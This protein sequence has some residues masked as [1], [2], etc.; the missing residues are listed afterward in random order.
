MAPTASADAGSNARVPALRAHAP[1]TLGTLARVRTGG[2]CVCGASAGHAARRCVGAR[3]LNRVG[4]G[5]LLRAPAS[6]HQL[7]TSPFSTGATTK[8]TRCA[9]RYVLQ[10]SMYAAQY[11]HV[12]AVRAEG[13][14]MGF[15]LV[16]V[17]ASFASALRR[18][19]DA[20]VPG[21]AIECAFTKDNTS[22]YVRMYVCTVCSPNHRPYLRSNAYVTQ[23]PTHG[24][25]PQLPREKMGRATS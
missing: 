10:S 25:E 16:G 6:A 8:C 4:C 7:A 18:V 17:G 24:F 9:Y 13:D 14:E 20:E 2:A 3:V 15:H 19:L 12:R 5:R 23:N 1:A 11:A 22:V 21:M